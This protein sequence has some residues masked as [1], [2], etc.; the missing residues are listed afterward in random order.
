MCRAAAGSEWRAAAAST[1]TFH[2]SQ[3]RLQLLVTRFCCQQ[4][5]SHILFPEMEKFFMEWECARRSIK[6]WVSIKHQQVKETDSNGRVVICMWGKAYLT[7]PKSMPRVAHYC[8]QYH[9]FIW[10]ILY[11]CGTGSASFIPCCNLQVVF[12]W[13]CLWTEMKPLIL[14]DGVDLRLD[15]VVKRFH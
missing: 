12:A 11:Q 14:C 13:Y 3:S 10:D 1:G 5:P 9:Q 4:I 15:L 2:C 7:V 6:W 8:I